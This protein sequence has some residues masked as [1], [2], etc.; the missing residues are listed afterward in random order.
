MCFDRHHTVCVHWQRET[1]RLHLLFPQFSKLANPEAVTA[2]FPHP[3]PME[4]VVEEREAE[5]AAENRHQRPNIEEQPEVCLCARGSLV[6]N[7]P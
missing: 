2:R 7:Q 1:Y 4:Q 5:Q 3:E 6:V